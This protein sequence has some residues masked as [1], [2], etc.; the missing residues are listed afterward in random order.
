MP[1]DQSRVDRLSRTLRRLGFQLGRTGR[2]FR[3]FDSEGKLA[4]GSKG[5]LSVSEVENW[6]AN[7]I[8][9]PRKGT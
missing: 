2:S 1:I 3:I 4:E 9:P 5:A 8:K 7:Y 6:I